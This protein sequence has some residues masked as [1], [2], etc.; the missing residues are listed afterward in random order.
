MKPRSLLL[1]RKL[2]LCLALAM[3]VSAGSALLAQ[4]TLVSGHVTDSDGS[5]VT[6]ADIDISSTSTNKVE[7]THSNADG[8]FQFPPLVPGNYILHATAPSFARYTLEGIKLE[9]GSSR[10]LNITLLPETTSYNVSVAASAPE[11][12]TDHPDRGNVI[13]SQFVQNTPLNIRNPLQLVNFAQGVTA[14]SSESGN[15]DQSQAYTNTFRINGS[16]LA[17]TE[18]LLDGAANTTLYDYNAAAAIPQV[19][20][21]QEFKVL[22]TAYAPEWGRTSGGIVTFATRSGS[23]TLHGSVFEYLRNSVL[24]ANG[25]NANAAGLKKPHFQ[26]N[27]FGYALGG[28]VRLPHLYNGENRTF[29]FSTFE[30]LRQSQAGSFLGTVPTARERQG[31]FSQSRDVNGNQIVIYDPRTTRLDPSAPAG[32]TQYIRTP[33]ANN[34]IPG[35]V[36]NATGLALLSYYPLPNQAG[37]GASTTNNYFSNATTSSNQNTVGLRIDHKISEHHSIYGRFNWFQRNNVFPDPYGNGLSP[38]P[39]N[40]RLPGYNMMFDHTWI[41]STNLVFEH[42]F[43]YAHQESNRAP[44]SVGFDPTSLGFNG[45]VVAGLSST[46]FPEL[47]ATRISGIGPQGGLEKDYGSLTE[48]AASLTQLK[49]KHSLKYG[50]DYRTFPVGL[51]IAQ[52][53]TV[54]AASNFTGGPN[55]QAA[56]GTSGSGIADL[57]LGAATVSSGVA[58][59]FRVNHPYYAIYAQDEYHLTPRLTLTYGLRYNLELPDREDHNQYVYLDLT[60]PSP[61]NA[62]VSS[63]GQLTG[64]PGFVGTNG[65][66]RRLQVAQ[67]ENFDPRLGFAYRMDDKTVVRGGFGIFHA[68]P[69]SLVN[70]SAGFAVVTTSKSALADGVTPQF[71]LSNPFPAGLNQ[72]TGSSLG[73][74]TLAGQNITGVMRQQKISYSEQWSFDVQRQLPS[75]IVVTLGYVGNNGL[76]LYIPVNYN[77]L[78]SSQLALGSSLLTTV[79]NPFYGVITDPTSTLSAPTVQR[80]QLLR[81]HPQFQNM[82][83]TSGVGNSTYHALQLSVERRFSQG[84]ALLFT[85]THSKMM[86]NVGDYFNQAQ[87]QNTDCTRCDRSISSQD[88]TNVIRLSGQYELPFG[89][90]KHFFN[91]GALS[92]IFGGFTVGTFFTYDN[93]LPIAVSSPNYSNSFG[94][95]TAMRPDVTGI[96]THVPGGR[97]IR[98]GGLYFN[99]AAF[100]PTPSY[101]FGNA[102][103]FLADV[104][105]PGTTNFDMLAARRIRLPEPFT[106]DFRMEFF[107]AFNRV[108]FAGPN[109]SIASSSFGQIFLTQANTARQLQAGLRLSF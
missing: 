50:F 49:G 55:P 99:P 25:Y 75:N 28:P 1:P 83:A 37:Q 6:N 72:P 89:R 42:H 56:A 67:K 64:G 106:L 54:S 69:A 18:S 73:L 41:L 38:E 70:S 22:T 90:G 103:R 87:F 109:T 12:V 95:G 94:G 98:N 27:Q 71:N 57:L 81:P 77:Q 60:T 13:E 104:R 97:Q 92:D 16:K 20:A 26:R 53:V 15:N 93:G 59:A 35:S 107:N 96:S 51:N 84:L 108:Q 10:S 33:F 76:H 40:Q 100:T 31:D 48:Y 79:A 80:G 66:G 52:L 9:V 91:Q 23:N 39:G 46:T 36:I 44:T 74:D 105:A 5:A 102:P 29:F 65:Q 61:L 34:M 2:S 30:G 101:Q 7:L 82:T 32:T 21:I 14:Y 17:T 45:N 63:L 24:D 62:N 88:L 8:Y 47:T 3:L 68:P 11:L 43:V 4:S 58:P 78:P 86:D 85:Y 19:D